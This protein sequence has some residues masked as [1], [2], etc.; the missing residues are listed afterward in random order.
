[1]SVMSDMIR[2]QFKEG[3]DIRDAG[4]TTPDGI[5]RFDDIAYICISPGRTTDNANAEEFSGAGIVSYR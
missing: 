3:D 2:A 5:K 1:M 4:L